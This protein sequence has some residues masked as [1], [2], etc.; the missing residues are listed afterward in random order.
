MKTRA[1]NETK[2][3]FVIFFPETKNYLWT[4]VSL[5]RP[6]DE[7]PQ[8]IVHRTHD[9]GREEVKDVTIPHIFIMQK[10]AV[11]MLNIIEQLHP[12]VLNLMVIFCF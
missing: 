3:Q 11:S 4:D 6:I 5:I 8:P 7:S 2:M 10:L 12:K 9:V 1:I